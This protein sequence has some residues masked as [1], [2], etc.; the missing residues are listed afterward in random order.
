MCIRDSLF[1]LALINI[2]ECLPRKVNYS[3]FADDLAIYTR[4]NNI[5]TLSNLLQRSISKLEQWYK[6]RDLK[7][8]TAKTKA[9]IF[10]RKTVIPTTLNIHLNNTPILLAS[11]ATFLGLTFDQRLTWKQHIKSLKQNCLIRMNLLKTMSRKSW[12]VSRKLLLRFYQIYVRSIMDYGCSIY[13]A[14]KTSLIK[15]LDTVQNTAIRISTGAFTTSPIWNLHADTALLTLSHHRHRHY[16]TLV[17][18]AKIR[19]DRNNINYYRTLHSPYSHQTIL[20]FG[21]RCQALL[22]KYKIVLP[23]DNKVPLQQ[24]KNHILT[25]M[26]EKFQEEWTQQATSSCTRLR[27]L[28]P[29]INRGW[30]VEHLNN[31]KNEVILARLRIGHTNFTHSPYFTNPEPPECEHCSNPRLTVSHILNTCPRYATSRREIYRKTATEDSD[32][33]EDTPN[34]VDLLFSFLHQ[35]ALYELL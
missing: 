5:E 11:K 23:D 4:G 13:S 2:N 10:S 32:I 19:N 7:F 25:C 15:K 35:T 22:Q 24:I 29:E 34:K 31:R 9:I 16:V 18:Y 20:S 14:A 30:Q 1:I 12:G 21:S 28:K 33:M 17:Q 27:M 6:S 3:L 8:S 26:Q